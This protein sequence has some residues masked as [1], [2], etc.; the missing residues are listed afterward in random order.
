MRHEGRKDTWIIFIGF[1]SSRSVVE[2]GRHGRR[3]LSTLKFGL[4]I[5]EVGKAA[6]TSNR[7]VTKVAIGG[8][9]NLYNKGRKEDMHAKTVHSNETTSPLALVGPEAVKGVA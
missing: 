6:L 4:Y 9:V 2:T 5:I 8:R 3:G 7:G 1:N